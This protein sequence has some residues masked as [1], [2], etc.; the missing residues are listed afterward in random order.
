MEELVAPLLWQQAMWGGG[1]LW[2]GCQCWL[3]E[4]GCWWFGAMVQPSFLHLD[5]AEAPWISDEN[6]AKNAD[7]TH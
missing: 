6:T 5:Q 2:G 7:V 3:S 4:I 1:W